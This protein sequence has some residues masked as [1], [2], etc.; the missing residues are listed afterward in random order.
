VN[1][2]VL[3]HDGLYDELIEDFT[4]L[5]REVKARSE[6]DF[7]VVTVAPSVVPNPY[8]PSFRVYAY[9]VTAAAD[10]SMLLKKTK[11]DKKDKK[12]KKKKKGHRRGPQKGDR[13]KLCKEDEAR[14]KS[15]RCHLAEEWHSDP[16]APCR[17]NKLW[18]PLGYAQVRACVRACVGRG[19]ACSRLACVI[20]GVLCGGLLTDGLRA[21]P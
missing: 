9:N 2:D 11:K 13:F 12:K 19:R 1:E 3:G 6:D 21:A 8:L 14:L 16:D 15:W 7:A 10:G 18:T 20:Y 17:T 4:A 5:R